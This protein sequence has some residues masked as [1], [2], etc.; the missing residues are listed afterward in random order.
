MR[1]FVEG[2][3]VGSIID[4]QDE[5][6]NKAIRRAVGGAFLARNLLEYES[7][8]DSTLSALIERLRKCPIFNLYDTFQSFQLDFLFKIAFSETP[9]H[10]EECKD[11]LGLAKL[12]NK[13][14]S[15]WFAWQPVPRLERAIFHSQICG[16]WLARPSKWVLMG[17]ERLKARS[18]SSKEPR[19]RND[20]LQKYVDASNRHSDVIRPETVSN[21]VNSTVSAGADTTAGTMTTIMYFLLKNSK[22]RDRLLKEL[23]EAKLSTPP[24][25]AEVSKLPYLDAVIK[26]ALRLHPPLAVPLERIVPDEGC[27]LAGIYL[28]P[29]TVVGCIGKLVH[30]DKHCFGDTPDRFCPERWLVANA[31]SRQA[32]ERGFISWGS[33]GRICLGRYIAE[34][35]MKKVIPSILLNFNVSLCHPEAFNM[36]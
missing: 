4:M 3:S 7:D 30:L 23:H 16:R 20:L 14:V 18:S 6:Q 33:G 34:L 26:E 11:V 31:A 15:H 19:G 27:T 13:R 35:E 25:Y 5:Q 28:P 2:V 21:L 29:K 24:C 17:K 10:L 32:M 8:V 22:S 12:G 36:C 1:V 9:A